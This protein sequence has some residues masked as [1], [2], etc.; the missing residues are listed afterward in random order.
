MPEWRNAFAVMGWG[1]MLDFDPVS[2]APRVTAPTL[3][4]H[5]DGSAFPE[6][7]RKVF[8]LLAGP[9]ELHGAEG[10]HL[11]FYDQAKQVR[12]SADRVAAHFRTNL[13]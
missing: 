1:P 9:K 6:Q 8:E 3:V 7:A 11:D 13:A 2:K 4:I 12:E 10:E 5:S